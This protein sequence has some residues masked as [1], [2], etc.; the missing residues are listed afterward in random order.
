MR[1]KEDRRIRITKLAIRESLIELMQQ[2]PIS[3]ISVKMICESADINRST[4]YAHYTNQVDLLNQLQQEVLSGIQESIS[5]TRFN[6]ETEDAVIVI[7]QI[8][9]YAK[10]N[11][12]LFKVLLS[13]HGDSS[14]QNGLLLLAQQKALEEELGEVKYLDPSIR[15]Y[16]ELFAIHGILSIIRNWLNDG[17]IEESAVLAAFILKILMQGISSLY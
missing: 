3:K 7:V 17:C 8:L 16:V 1:K 9:E 14:F 12:T 10:A 11:T 2:Y 15:K 5:T 4:F 6:D 13:E